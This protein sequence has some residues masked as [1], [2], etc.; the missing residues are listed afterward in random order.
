MWYVIQTQTGREQEL[1]ECIER[2][3]MR[4]HPARPDFRGFVPMRSLVY[5]TTVCGGIQ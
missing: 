5:Y 2:V 4:P 3:F 1:T